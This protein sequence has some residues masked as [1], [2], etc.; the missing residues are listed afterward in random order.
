MNG[1]G[2]PGPPGPS[3]RVGHAKIE[4]DDA[5]VML[6]DDAAEYDAFAPD[7]MVRSA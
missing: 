4:M 2:F 5:V 1:C 3:G 6:A 7:R